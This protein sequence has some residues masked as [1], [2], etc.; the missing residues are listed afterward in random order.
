[1]SRPLKRDRLLADGKCPVCDGAED[2][3]PGRLYGAACR[4]KQCAYGKAWRA[5]RRVD[6]AVIVSDVS[7]WD[8][9]VDGLALAI[10]EADDSGILRVTTPNDLVYSIHF[11]AS[12]G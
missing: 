10:N 4:D 8:V 2:V 5:H 9:Q 11:N 3:L 12:E 6:P 7:V 1:M